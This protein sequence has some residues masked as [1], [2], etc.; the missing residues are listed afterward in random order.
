MAS[1]QLRWS[2]HE[3]RK[4]YA[5]PFMV[6]FVNDS[7]EQL[8]SVAMNGSTCCTGVSSSRPSPP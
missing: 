5:R 6:T 2:M 3:A 8:G 7:G 1:L 4:P